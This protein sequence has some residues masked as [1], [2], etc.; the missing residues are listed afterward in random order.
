LGQ[1]T[2]LGV[3]AR[4]KAE[5]SGDMKH[6]IRYDHDPGGL[7]V[8]QATQQVDSIGAKPPKGSSPKPLATAF[9]QSAK[10]LITPV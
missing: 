10:Q 3:F 4:L 2:K 5:G 7:L 1:G 6:V 8:R 9:P